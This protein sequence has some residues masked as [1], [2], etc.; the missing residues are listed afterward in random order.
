LGEGKEN[1]G[2]MFF[3]SFTNKNKIKS[4]FPS[5]LRRGMLDI[6][7]NRTRKRKLVNYDSDTLIVDFYWV[8]SRANFF[9]IF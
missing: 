8:L 6:K 1:I 4:F 5:K 7:P 3:L 2:S 9:G